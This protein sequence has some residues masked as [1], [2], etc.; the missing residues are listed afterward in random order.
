MFAIGVENQLL[1][2]ITLLVGAAFALGL[3]WVRLAKAKIDR[4]KIVLATAL[5]PLL[6][7][8]FSHLLYC[9]ADVEYTIYTYSFGYLFAFW[10]RGTM[11]Y[12]GIL[13]VFLGLLLIGGQD[14]LKMLEQYAP[15]A[16]WMIAAARIG[17]GFLGQGYGEYWE[18]EA[19]F[20][21][22]FPFMVYDP[23]YEAWGWAL[24]VL[25]AL[26]ALALFAFLLKKRAAWQGDGALLLLGLYASA[27]IVLE[28]LRR[29]EFLRWGFVRVEQ[30]TSAIAV[31]AVLVC[32]CLKAGRGRGLFKALC[33]AS[34]GVLIVFCLLLEFALEG[35]VPFLMFLDTSACYVA[36]AGASALLGGMVLWMRRLCNGQYITL[37][38]EHHL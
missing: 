36:M 1:C 9:L 35:R 2:G 25:E 18:G 20:F 12:G 6:A 19:F 38:K 22:R 5:L 23:Y 32:Y 24:F 29:D 17:E 13:G 21:H 33:F 26:I 28:S 4:K 14:R 34:Y 10:E 3:G 31:F 15:S 11:L 7:A 27:Q 30:V 37:G 8:F 16:A